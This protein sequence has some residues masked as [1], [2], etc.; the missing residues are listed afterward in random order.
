MRAVAFLTT[1][2]LK[3]LVGVF[4]D[5]PKTESL[6]HIRL[7]PLVVIVDG[8]LTSDDWF[9]F[10]C[11]GLFFPYEKV[12]LIDVL[13]GYIVKGLKLTEPFKSLIGGEM[14]FTST[15]TKRTVIDTLPKPSHEVTS[16]AAV[17]TQISFELRDGHVVLIHLHGDKD[18]LKFGYFLLDVLV[19]DN[20]TRMIYHS[21]ILPLGN[22]NAMS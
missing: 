2:V 14:P 1:L 19:D 8:S 13:Q 12:E 20:S 9:P 11:V 7:E 16:V 15:F 17:R 6:G 10:G 18:M 4:F 5:K 21:S 3:T 22:G